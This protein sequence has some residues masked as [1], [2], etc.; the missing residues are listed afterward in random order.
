MTTSSNEVFFLLSFA[1]CYL[2]RRLFWYKERGR[3]CGMVNALIY[4]SVSVGFYRF[5]FEIMLILREK[6]PIH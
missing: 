3:E 5:L 6:H 4:V 1:L 2:E